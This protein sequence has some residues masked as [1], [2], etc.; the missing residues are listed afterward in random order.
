MSPEQEAVYRAFLSEY[1][2][3]SGATLNLSNVTTPFA[4]DENAKK[5]C[6]QGFVDVTST[7]VHSFPADFA[8]R[9]LQVIDALKHKLED[10]AKAIKAGS[11]VEQAVRK[12]FASGLLTLSEVVFDYQHQ[13]AAF[14]F[15]FVCGGLCGDGGIL[16]FELRDGRWRRAKSSCPQWIS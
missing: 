4:P 16:V 15:S 5:N 12:G 13:K 11:D 1:N 6:L 7:T 9:K 14:S 3:G 10:P 8:G 2:N